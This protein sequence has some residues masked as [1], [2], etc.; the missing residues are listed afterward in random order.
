LV[1]LEGGLEM[2]GEST[3]IRSEA[4]ALSR[5]LFMDLLL[6]L[7]LH[8]IEGRWVMDKELGLRMCFID[9]DVQLAEGKGW[10][11]EGM[12]HEGFGA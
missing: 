7:V 3:I 6:D 4:V 12:G 8:V 9:L 10:V 1:V 2:E 11:M 5:S